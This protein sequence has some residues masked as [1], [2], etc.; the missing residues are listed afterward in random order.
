MMSFDN[1]GVVPLMTV[2]SKVVDSKSKKTYESNKCIVDVH[3]DLTIMLGGCSGLRVINCT[4]KMIESSNPL[5]VMG[6]TVPNM[7][8]LA[9]KLSKKVKQ[10]N[11]ILVVS[12]DLCEKYTNIYPGAH[13]I[14]GKIKEYCSELGFSPEYGWVLQIMEVNKKYKWYAKHAN[15]PKFL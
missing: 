11:G 8:A 12:H 3:D 10:P 14:K 6:A 15:K 1:T 2:E 7:E 5:E 9:K 13:R 4:E